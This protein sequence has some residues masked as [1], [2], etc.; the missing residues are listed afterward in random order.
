MRSCLV[1][2]RSRFD[3]GLGHHYISSGVEGHDPKPIREMQERRSMRK[4]AFKSSPVGAK[5][6]VTADTQVV[7]GS[8]VGMKTPAY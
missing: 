5:S 4:D 7:L 8:I 2:R 1:S 3:S 6:M